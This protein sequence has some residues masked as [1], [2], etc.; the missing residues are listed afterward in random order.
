MDLGT[1]IL[2][3]F[4]VIAVSTATSVGISLSSPGWRSWV[5]RLSTAVAKEQAGATAEFEAL[6]SP[7]SELE[8]RLDF[9][10][11][12]LAT[13]SEQPARLPGRHDP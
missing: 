11:R 10:E 1:C 6:K 2:L 9:V 13:E 8:E 7:V 5:T 4:V 3:R 12:V